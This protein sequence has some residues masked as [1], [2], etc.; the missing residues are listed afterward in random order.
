MT[1]TNQRLPRLQARNPEPEITRQTRLSP[2]GHRYMV[3]DLILAKTFPFAVMEKE[4]TFH[5]CGIVHA[6]EG[7]V[8]NHEI[9]LL[10]DG[11]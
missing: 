6:A 7:F 5:A 10:D 1:D 11:A 8:E 4:D 9:G 3:K 2:K